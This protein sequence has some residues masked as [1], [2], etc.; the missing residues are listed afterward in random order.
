M[1]D[2]KLFL[3]IAN[4]MGIDVIDGPGKDMINGTEVDVM[5]LLFKELKSSDQIQYNEKEIIRIENKE[6]RSTISKKTTGDNKVLIN[7]ESCFAA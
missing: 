7:E 3:E 6:D 5:D 2:K 4:E 1:F